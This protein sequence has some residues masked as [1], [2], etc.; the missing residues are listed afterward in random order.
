MYTMR[1]KVLPIA[2]QFKHDHEDML[3]GKYLKSGCLVDIAYGKSI[4]SNFRH[5]KYLLPNLLSMQGWKID[6]CA[7]MRIGW[8]I[9]GIKQ[10]NSGICGVARLSHDKVFSRLFSSMKFVDMLNTKL[11]FYRIWHLSKNIIT[12]MS[13]MYCHLFCCIFS[14]QAIHILRISCNS[15]TVFISC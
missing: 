15:A 9:D 8:E 14:N 7:V 13:N 4:W 2:L 5:S 3:L 10:S 12:A 6:W 11:L 1:S